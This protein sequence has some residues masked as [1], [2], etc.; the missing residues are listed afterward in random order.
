MKRGQEKTWGGASAGQ[1]SGWVWIFQAWGEPA[2][3]VSEF[4]ISIKWTSRFSSWKLGFCLTVKP[5]KAPAFLEHQ[6]PVR[7]SHSALSW[8]CLPLPLSGMICPRGAFFIKDVPVTYSGLLSG[9]S[10][11]QEWSHLPFSNLSCW[12]RHKLLRFRAVTGQCHPG[13][14]YGVWYPWGEKYYWLKERMNYCM[15]E[16]EVPELLRGWGN[17]PEGI[18]LL[19]KETP[20]VP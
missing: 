10:W 1:V 5:S 6:S 20:D 19:F 7:Y 3:A 16:K 13:A 4:H 9:P 18:G 15:E 14:P 17:C 12:T 2:R 11:C 8:T